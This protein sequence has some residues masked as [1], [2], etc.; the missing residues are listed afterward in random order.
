MDKIS[1]IIR[2][3]NEER[4]IGHAIQSCLD[5]IEYPEII[6][7]ND[8]SDDDSIKIA[9]MFSHEPKLE[10]NKKYTD[11]KT[12]NIDDYSPGRAINLGVRN[13]KYDSI[14]LIS[15]HCVLKKINVD[16]LK[17]KLNDY[18][19]IFGQQVPFYFGKRI[20]KNYIWSHFKEEEEKNM[21]SNLENRYFMHNALSFFEKSTL[22]KFPFNETLTGKEDRYWAIDMIESKNNILYSPTLSCDH[23]YTDKGNTWKGIG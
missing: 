2:C 13:A 8:H 14:L 11:V 18:C 4:W 10:K 9:R 6:I 5:L 1:I 19:C 21:Y 16:F 12:L 3:H 7:V 20:T 15:S 17:S 23:H 22:I